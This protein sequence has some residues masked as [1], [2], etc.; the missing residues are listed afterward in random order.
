MSD[1]TVTVNRRTYQIACDEGQEERLHD[2]AQLVDNRVEELATANDQIGDQRLLVMASLLLA[3]EVEDMRQNL[4]DTK[5]KLDELAAVAM[6][7]NQLA[8]VIEEMAAKI[9][10]LDSQIEK[11]RG[12]VGR[13]HR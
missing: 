8:G 12:P 5:K 11:D 2:L 1:V 3:D 4:Q 9:E 10:A 7:E 13:F 6:T